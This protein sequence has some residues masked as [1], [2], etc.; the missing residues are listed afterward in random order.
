MVAK[1]P[2]QRP[3]VSKLICRLSWAY[4][5]LVMAWNEF[6]RK[7]WCTLDVIFLS[8]PDFLI[9]QLGLFYKRLKWGCILGIPAWIVFNVTKE[10]RND[11]WYVDRRAAM[12]QKG[13]QTDA[14]CHTAWN[15][16]GWGTYAIVSSAGSCAPCARV[17]W[18]SGSIGC[19]NFWEGRCAHNA[20]LLDYMSP[21]KFKYCGSSWCCRY[22]NWKGL[23]KN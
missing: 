17:V 21:A 8:L 15:L 4:F 10:M 23:E 11:K 20:S 18:I 13:V 14:E 12:T 5:T 22:Q 9:V 6:R 19:I 16:W 1:A 2:D 3:N 7:E